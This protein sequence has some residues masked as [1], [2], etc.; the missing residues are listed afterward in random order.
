MYCISDILKK[1]KDYS[2]SL[3]IGVDRSLE[4]D[5]KSY[6]GRE[7]IGDILF[8]THVVTTGPPWTFCL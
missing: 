7:T 5:G 6:D 2:Y 3:S 4:R 1:I 8:K